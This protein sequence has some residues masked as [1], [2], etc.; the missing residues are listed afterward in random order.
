LEEKIQLLNKLGKFDEFFS[1]LFPGKTFSNEI[2]VNES[3]SI[4]LNNPI[5]YTQKRALEEQ[6]EIFI[7]VGEFTK[8]L[9]YMV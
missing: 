3:I 2:D 9:K 6:A 5:F 8:A 7:N 1:I 4:I